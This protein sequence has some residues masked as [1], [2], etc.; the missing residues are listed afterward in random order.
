MDVISPWVSLGGPSVSGVLRCKDLEASDDERGVNALGQVDACGRSGALQLQ[1]GFGKGR[2]VL[3]LP[4][5]WLLCDR[6][7]GM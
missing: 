5:G 4:L 6:L 1:R 7:R 3:R 2:S